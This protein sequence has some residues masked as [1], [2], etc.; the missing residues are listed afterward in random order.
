M[1]NKK[2]EVVF[3]K[4]PTFPPFNYGYA[5][6]DVAEIP[7]DDAKKLFE[8]KVCGVPGDDESEEESTATAPEGE[9]AMTAGGNPTTPRAR[10]KKKK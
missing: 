2:I 8:L 10:R 9:T 3:I 4:S 5:I 6:G 1:S 7:A